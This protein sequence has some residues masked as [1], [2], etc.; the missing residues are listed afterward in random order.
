MVYMRKLGFKIFMLCA[1]ACIASCKH[2][3]EFVVSGTVN[4]AGDSTRFVIESAEN[5]TWF[6]VDSVKPNSKG[7]FKISAEAPQFPGIYRLRYNS[8]SI[9]FP[10]DS[11]EH[12]NITTGIEGF[13]TDFEV[14]GSDHAVQVMNI[15][16]EALKYRNADSEQ[17]AAW[18]RTLSDRI[19]SDPGGIVSYYIINKYIDGKP[20]FDPA[21]DSDVRVIGAVANLF[22]QYHPKDPRTNYLVNMVLAAQRERRIARGSRDTVEV[23]S[24][25]LFNIDL[26]D[27]N[28]V[29]HNLQS[30]ADNGKVV[31]LNFTVY[32]ADFS[33]ALNKILNDVYSAHK[34]QL[35]IYQ[36]S[37]DRDDVTYRTAARNLPWITVYD[38]TGEQSAPYNLQG[39]PTTFIIN[40]NGDVAERVADESELPNIIKRY[41]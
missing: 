37:L 13:D 22:R 25:S 16:K 15:D 41:L 5:G 17:I 23:T 1:I 6:I 24:A 27:Y 30:I 21:D 11:L 19:I 9:Y 39:V 7:E 40:R 4:G 29:K 20:L 18:K 28:G 31:I 8:Q 3:N 14:S 26:Q 34:S 33:P 12:I 36:V 38:P 35:E 2:S 10:I 32:A